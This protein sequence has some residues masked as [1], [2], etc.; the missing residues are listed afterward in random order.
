MQLETLRPRKG[1]DLDALQALFEGRSWKAALPQSLPDPILIALAKD[2]RGVEAYL[3]S[4]DEPQE[5]PAAMA[6]A[7][8]AITTLLSRDDKALA[9]H[10]QRISE[11]GLMRAM[12]VYQ[13][14]VEREIVSRITGISTSIQSSSFVESLERCAAD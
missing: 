4:D 13:W 8:L 12:Q 2:L 1:A 3:C 7:V 14:G 6:P 9:M 11:G 10:P 5:C